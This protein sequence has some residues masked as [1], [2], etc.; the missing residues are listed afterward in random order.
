MEFQILTYGGLSEISISLDI[1]ADIERM[2]SDFDDATV[3]MGRSCELPNE[4]SRKPIFSYW[5]LR[6]KPQLWRCLFDDVHMPELH[7]KLRHV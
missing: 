7:Y 3:P 6:R 5:T 2:D 4:L 1:G